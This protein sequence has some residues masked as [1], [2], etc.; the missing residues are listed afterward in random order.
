[1][2]A[3]KKRDK[4]EQ[5][6]KKWTERRKK[7][8]AN[9]IRA[10][11]IESGHKC[12]NP[13]CR[14]SMILEAH[15][16]LWVKDGGGDQPENLLALCPNCHGMHTR[17]Q[18]GYDAIWHWKQMLVMLNHA[19]DKQGIDQLLFLHNTKQLPIWVDAGSIGQYAA[20]IASRLVE[21]AEVRQK[22]EDGVCVYST[23]PGMPA[24]ANVAAPFVSSSCRIV[25]TEKGRLLVDAWLSADH[26]KYEKIFL[27][28]A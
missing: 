10:V 9:V 3:N 8:P 5:L 7:L 11:F 19:Y 6:E 21:V 28:P 2:P 15:H 13:V 26:R 22:V 24:S 4:A 1:M 17:G 23:A 20:L 12:A 18:I 25:L 14:F 16:I 27:S